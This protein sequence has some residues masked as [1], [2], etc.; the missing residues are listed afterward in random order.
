MQRIFGREYGIAHHKYIYASFDQVNNVF[1]GKWIGERGRFQGFIV[2]R[3]DQ[4]PN[5]HANPNAVRHAGGRFEGDILDGNRQKIG[6]LG[7]KY[8]SHPHFKKGF[9]QGR[10]KLDCNEVEDDRD[11]GL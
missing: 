9:I 11:D 3:W 5:E 7:G 6:V 1:F 4:H 8:K 2:G 10:W